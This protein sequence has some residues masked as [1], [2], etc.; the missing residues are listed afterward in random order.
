[1]VTP[2]TW[3]PGPIVCVG[4]AGCCATLQEAVD[5]AHDGDTMSMVRLPFDRG[6]VGER[7]RTHRRTPGQGRFRDEPGDRRPTE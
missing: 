5:A 3:L 2:P 4:V 7:R 1:M 6:Q